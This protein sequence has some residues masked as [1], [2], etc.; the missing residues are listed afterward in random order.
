MGKLQTFEILFDHDKTEYSS[1]DSVTG[2]VKVELSGSLQCKGKKL[3]TWPNTT[4][5]EE[6]SQGAC[7]DLSAYISSS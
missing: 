5:N 4:P 1:G 7:L 2:S 3:L 6:V